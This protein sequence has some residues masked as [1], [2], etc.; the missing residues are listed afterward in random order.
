MSA[1][2]VRSQQWDDRHFPAWAWP[3][4]WLL[5]AFSS[6]WLA[7]VLLSL[8]GV[9]GILASVPIGMIA[10]IPTVAVYALTLLAAVALGALL[11]TWIALRGLRGLGLPRASRFVA[12]FGLALGLAAL[13]TLAWQRFAWPHLRYSDTTREGFRL[14]A[15]FVREYQS[16]P[17]RRLPG[18]EMSEL[19]FYAWWPL[20]LVLILFVLNMTVATLRRIEFSVPNLGVLTVHAGIV[21]IALGSAYYATL[22]QEGDMLLAAGPADEQGRPTPGRPEPGFFDNTQTVLWIN[23]RDVWEQRALSGV[24]RYNPYFLSA[25]GPA[26]DA[27]ADEGRTLG[28]AVPQPPAPP[29]GVEPP[30]DL[31]VRFRV[32]GYADYAEL[33]PTW[34]P[35]DAVDLSRPD[36]RRLRRVDLLSAVGGQPGSAPEQVRTLDFA[37]DSPADRVVAFGDALAVE[38]T[39]GMPEARW[40][41]LRAVLPPGVAHALAISIPASGTHEAFERVIPVTVGQ[42]LDVP[43]FRLEVTTLAPQPPFPIVTPGYEGAT[44]SL[45]VVRVTPLIDPAAKPFE[46][47]V[48]HRFPEIAQDLS[49]ELNERG[50]PRRKP[51]DPAI[52]IHYLDA[53]LAQ[54]YLDE[55]PAG[56]TPSAP[57]PVRALIRLPGRPPTVIDDLREP[58][59]IAPMVALRVQPAVL[60]ARK[61]EVPALTP[62]RD[63]DRDNIGNHRKAALALEV[64]QVDPAN[65]AAPPRFRQVLWLPF[66]QYLQL[67][68]E[69]HRTVTLPD[70]RRF[71]LAFG[72]RFHALPDLA[73][74]LVD[75]TMTPYPHTDTPRDFRSDVRVIR[76]WS[77]RRYQPEDRATSL[78]DPLLV[79]VPFEWSPERPALVNLIG[80]MIALVAPN[81]YKF[82]QTGWDAAGWR[83]S[84]ARAAAGEIPRPVAGFTILGV[85]NN[86][87]IYVIA[88]GAV[89]MSL[90]IPWAF[91]V[92]PWIL[93]RRKRLIQD[94][95]ARGT[96]V[97]PPRRPTAAAE[98]PA[99]A[100]AA[101]AGARQE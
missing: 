57:G 71:T 38:F 54:V 9:F 82:S 47:W 68:P 8:V 14:F 35:A 41:A 89:M 4:K 94:Q 63:R 58:A 20:E 15:G 61:V 22:K 10:L 96:Y 40:N 24:P 83:Q 88:A 56:G 26:P 91:Y 13:S 78:N 16:L 69:L 25:A 65:P 50:M 75:F 48:Y 33:R 90:G 37:P 80:S 18:M 17:L 36:V 66:A 87:G 1:K 86:P 49:D 3:A 95:L 101:P 11:P 81:Q 7:V 92:K 77:T 2:W 74:Q 23:Q 62:E 34:A 43:G 98:S 5:R 85:G 97:R 64:T 76:G 29:E 55:R 39:R 30:V 12:S 51:A 79:R 72:R 67:A 42:T 28:L 52:T 31:D 84:A 53:T 19:E 27:A 32:V 21:T 6:I 45:A 44:S 73:V 100:P 70:G 59:P 60:A 93:R 99:S 46:R